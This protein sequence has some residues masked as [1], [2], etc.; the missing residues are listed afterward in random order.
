[1]QGGFTLMEI[2]IVVAILAVLAG[3][4]SLG[5]G[6]IL[7]RASQ[8]AMR[9]EWEV[10]DKAMDAYNACISEAEAL[11]TIAPCTTPSVITGSQSLTFRKNLRND[12]TY[13]YLWEAGGDNFVA[14]DTGTTVEGSVRYSSTGFYRYTSGQWVRQ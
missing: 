9:V 7:D 5:A 11:P 13:Y 14:Q 10:V 1:M 8:R 3:I 12:T 2:L 6:P 4:V